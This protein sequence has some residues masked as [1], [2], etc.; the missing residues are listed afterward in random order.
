MDTR[1][2]LLNAVHQHPRVIENLA[3]PG[4]YAWWDR[5]GALLPLYPS[6]FPPVD[7]RLPLY[8]GI[9]KTSL[10][11]RGSGMHLSTTRC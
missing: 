4:L 1:E 10:G 5:K 6:G 8:V 3:E 11:T 9:A 7:V 2:A